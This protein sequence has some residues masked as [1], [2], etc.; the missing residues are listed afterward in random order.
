MMRELARIFVP[1]LL[2]ALILSLGIAGACT[3]A[4]AETRGPAGSDV[5]TTPREAL[6]REKPSRDSKS[7]RACPRGRV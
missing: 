2:I 7:W 6:L 4:A 5:F 1:R 3:Y